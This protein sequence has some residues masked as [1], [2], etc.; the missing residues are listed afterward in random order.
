[1]NIFADTSWE[2]SFSAPIMS[3]VKNIIARDYEDQCQL[4][5]KDFDLPPVIEV[6]KI[7]TGTQFLNLGEPSTY[8]VE[9][10]KYDS[11]LQ[12][13]V[14]QTFNVKVHVDLFDDVVE[15]IYE[16]DFKMECSKK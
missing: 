2:G 9:L 8:L 11:K 15:V 16:D 1:M 13:F 14:A 12:A 6:Q 4:T 5:F 3:E 7:E 10:K